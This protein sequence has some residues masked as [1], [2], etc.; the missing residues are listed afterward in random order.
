LSSLDE[1]FGSSK[2]ETHELIRDLHQ[3]RIKYEEDAH[4][5]TQTLHLAEIE[6]SEIQSDIQSS[7]S[8]DPADRRKA[9][10]REEAFRYRCINYVD[11]SLDR[12]GRD[13]AG[14]ISEGNFR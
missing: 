3:Y 4:A 12:I 11:E 9:T 7:K 2:P 10:A 8:R 13:P 1:L 5:H 14:G 6:L